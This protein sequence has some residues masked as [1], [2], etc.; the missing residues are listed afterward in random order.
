[1]TL[2]TNAAND[3]RYKGAPADLMEAAIRLHHPSHD[4][5]P[6][7]TIDTS[8]ESLAGY[9]WVD[10]GQLDPAYVHKARIELESTAGPQEPVYYVSRIDLD[11]KIDVFGLI[12]YR[13]GCHNGIV[14]RLHDAVDAIQ[15]PGLRA[16]VS[17][18]FTLYAVY[19]YFWTCPAS[20]HHHHSYRGGLALHSIE[21]AESAVKIP[22]LTTTE[23]D[24][25][26]VYGLLHDIGK[27][28]CYGSDRLFA[29]WS[30]HETAAVECLEQP[31]SR[32]HCTWPDAAY[33]IRSL[34]SGKWK[35]TG[36]RPIMAIGKLTQALDQVSVE[37]DLRR[38]SVLE[39]MPWTPSPE[40]TKALRTVEDTKP[41]SRSNFA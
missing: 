19:R 36:S 13:F 21:M 25:A 12:P 23:R 11:R 27:I 31:L 14:S 40:P 37:Q 33:A 34:L 29:T 15:S 30:D 26:V 2:K 1:M 35:T 3:N 18:V 7:I 22:H 10:A 20:Q 9:S 4:G 41:P 8:D 17:D 39:H 24:F 38:C 32:L 16:F 5:L 6:I 28:W